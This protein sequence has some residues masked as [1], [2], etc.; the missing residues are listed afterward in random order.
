[1]SLLLLAGLA[2]VAHGLWIPLKAQLAQ[3]LLDR[4]FDRAVVAGHP[5]KPWAWADTW[6]VARIEAPRLSVRQVVLE[7]GSGQAMAFA[8]GHLSASSRPGERGLAVFAAHRDTH[9]R[10]L[11]DLRRGDELLVTR[12]DGARFHF[13]VTGSKLTRWDQFSIDR[14]RALPGLALATCWPLDAVGHGPMR[15][16]VYAEAGP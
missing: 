6:P 8:P 14:N 7:G 1:M 11:R 5:V 13:R 4:A 10:F 3:V 2:L 15:L 16:V 9:F 12:A